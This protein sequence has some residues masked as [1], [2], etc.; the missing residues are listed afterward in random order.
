MLLSGA[1]GS[2]ICLLSSAVLG[3]NG[4]TFF[5]HGM[6]KTILS[7]LRS[8]QMTIMDPNTRSSMLA[9]GAGGRSAPRRS[10]YLQLFSLQRVPPEDAQTNKG[11]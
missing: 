7:F 3:V 2:E 11:S 5:F 10:A 1:A 4:R 9:A 8:P 6:Q